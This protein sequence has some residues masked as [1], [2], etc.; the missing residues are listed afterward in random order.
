MRGCTRLAWTPGMSCRT[1]SGR[2]D[3][4]RRLAARADAPDAQPCAI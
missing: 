2:A 1:P 4:R 3:D